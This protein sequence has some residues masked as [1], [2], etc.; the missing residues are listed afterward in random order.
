LPVSPDLRS[1]LHQ[2]EEQLQ[3][4][5]QEYPARIAIDRL[6]FALALTKF[7]RTQVDLD[8]TV[9]HTQPSSVR[10]GASPEL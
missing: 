3:L 2:I 6:K 9:E 7:V 8:A 4:S 5:M 10:V 1:K